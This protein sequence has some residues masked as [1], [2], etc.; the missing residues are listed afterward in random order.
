MLRLL[1]REFS[2]SLLPIL[3]AKDM[4]INWLIQILNH[5]EE[6]H[7]VPIDCTGSKGNL[8]FSPELWRMPRAQQD[9]S[10][11]ADM[12]TFRKG[13]ICLCR[14]TGAIGN[15][16]AHPKCP[17]QVSWYT[18][19]ALELEWMPGRTPMDTSDGLRCLNP[20]QQ[21]RPGC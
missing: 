2:Y 9:K 21:E 10:S 11:P 13:F 17:T 12:A 8:H 15:V 1:T 20:S 3:S 5:P 18:M 19:A 4:H 7:A 6:S 14:S 16:L